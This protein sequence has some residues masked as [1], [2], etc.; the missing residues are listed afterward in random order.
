MPTP[1]E[2]PTSS[3]P[4]AHPAE[5]QGRLL[6]VYAEPEQQ[7]TVWK[8][9]P[10]TTYFAD[11]TMN[12]PRGF[13]ESDGYIYGAYETHVQ[14]IGPDGSVTTLGGLLEGSDRV[15]WAKNNA[16]PTRHKVVVTDV[17]VFSVSTSAIS[18][19]PGSVLPP[20]PTSCCHLDGYLFFTYRDGQI[21]ATDLNSLTVNALSFTRADANPDG[22]LRGIVSGRQLFAMGQSSIEVYQDTGSSPFPLSRAAVIPV[23]LAGT[24]CAAGGNETDG[25]DSSPLFVAADGTVRQLQGYEPKIVSTRAVERF[26]A[27]V[28]DRTELDAY[29]YTFL[30]HSI[31]GLRGTGE[32][33]GDTCWEYNT[34]TGQWH[35]RRSLGTFS[36]RGKKTIRAWDKWFCGDTLSTELRE[37]N[38]AAQDERGQAL[39]CRIESKLMT[40]FPARMAIARADFKF[41]QGVGIVTGADPVQTNP[42][43]EI[44]WSDDGGGH[45]ARPLQRTLGREGE[46]GWSVRVNRTGM[47]TPQGRRWRIDFADRVPY[48]F[49]GATME[50][51]E[52]AS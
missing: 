48:V 40:N 45:W 32:R 7:Q 15:T 4:D 17:G 16:Y 28:A 8:R 49:V 50:L 37:I 22:L 19:F 23:G 3:F 34:S 52:R 10:G 18:S 20:N 11:V 46:Y 6:N 13:L 14:K 30:G 24:F 29:V 21:W 35:E 42:R 47:S 5:S 36:W 41:A 1:I 26:I 51:E 43:A 25:W 31:W 44:S 9:I 38:V 12:E 39:P 33:Q 27:N 2:F